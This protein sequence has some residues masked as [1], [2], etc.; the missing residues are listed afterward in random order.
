MPK[1]TKSIVDALAPSGA[2]LWCWDSTLPGFGVRAQASGRKTFV[3]RYRTQDGAQ[4]KMT[5]GRCCDI[6]PDQARE[7]A[8]KAFAAVATGQDPAVKRRESRAAPTMKELAER[9]MT[10]HAIPYKKPGSAK[11]DRKNWDKYVLPQIGSK[12]V[13]AVTRQD[14][15]AIHGGLSTTPVTANHVRAL[16]SKAMNLAID[17]GIRQSTNPCVGVKRYRI[18]QRERVLTPDEI[19]RLC[20]ALPPGPLGDLVR[21]LLLTGCRLNEVMKARREWVDEQRRLLLL[22]DSKV[23]QR[24]I[25]LSQAALDIIT[26]MPKGQTWLIPGKRA[27]TPMEKPYGS[28]YKIT[29]AAGLPGLR[30]HDLRHTAGSIGHMM[31]LTQRQ[32]ADMLGHSNLAT[33]ERYLHGYQED[34]ARAV[35]VLATRITSAWES[36]TI[37]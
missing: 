9:Y 24:R 16:I 5:L 1:L 15:L 37:N 21:L 18:R 17:W 20:A 31:G 35:D 36:P 11:Q 2:D 30:F 26:A 14:V 28:W 25:A 33:T 12:K 27:G 29:K 19:R 8:R 23:G 13:E 10:L 34:A 3:V 22:P 6:T 32:I 7:L 4:R